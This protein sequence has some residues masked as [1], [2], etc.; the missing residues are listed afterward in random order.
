MKKYVVVPGYVIS[1]YDGEKHFIDG[2]RLI[3]LY[4]V[5]PDECLMIDLNRRAE[6]MHAIQNLNLIVLGTRADGDYSIFRNGITRAK[7]MAKRR[8]HE[9]T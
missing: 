4:G 6:M 8:R 3:D 2:W 9:S 1:Q 7:Q 5:D